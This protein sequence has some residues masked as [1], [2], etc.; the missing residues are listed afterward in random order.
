[1]SGKEHVVLVSVAITVSRIYMVQ[2]WVV[3]KT[4]H[5]HQIRTFKTWFLWVLCNDSILLR[6]VFHLQLRK[7]S[8]RCEFFLFSMFNKI[9]S[10]RLFIWVWSLCILNEQ[11]YTMY[12]HRRFPS[13]IIRTITY[14]F[15]GS[16]CCFS[17]ILFVQKRI[18]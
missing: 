8:V 9:T 14:Y 2:W 15:N 3:L 11:T 5:D 7:V 4:V 1:M 16:V 18:I 6:N 13:M 10:I 17:L 12:C